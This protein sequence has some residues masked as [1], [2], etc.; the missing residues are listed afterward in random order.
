MS[1]QASS[2]TF[3]FSDKIDAVYIH[4]MYENDYLYMETMFKV[5][6][7]HFD[8]DLLSIQNNY[9][10]N[11]VEL[12]R[13]SVHKVRPSFSFVGMPVVQEKCMEFENKCQA[14]KSVSELEADF[15]AF[16]KC[17]EDARTVITEEYKRLQLFNEAGP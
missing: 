7:D 4:S 1:D 14:A 2:Q 13:K 3:V 5:V 6:V 15:P 12:L 9:G 10:Q 8:E 11:N 16:I 17:L